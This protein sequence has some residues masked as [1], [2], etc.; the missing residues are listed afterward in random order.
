MFTRSG[1][2]KVKADDEKERKIIRISKHGSPDD[3]DSKGLSGFW[4]HS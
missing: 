2:D 3:A 4:K 1:E